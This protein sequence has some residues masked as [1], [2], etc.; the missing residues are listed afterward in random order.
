MAQIEFGKSHEHIHLHGMLAGLP[1]GISP[2]AIKNIWE[3][4]VHEGGKA[5]VTTYDPHRDG[6]SYAMK[7]WR[8]DQQVS[9]VQPHESWPMCSDSIIDTLRRAGDRTN[10]C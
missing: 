1:E 8:D 7:F 2:E 3:K 9:L 6:V 10:Q 5:E 4:N